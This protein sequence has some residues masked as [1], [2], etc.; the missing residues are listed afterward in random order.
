MCDL[1]D[2][3]I[4]LHEY[5]LL[6]RRCVFHLYR[7]YRSDVL[8]A[9]TVSKAG[10]FFLATWWHAVSRTWLSEPPEFE[11]EN[12]LGRHLTTKRPLKAR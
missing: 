4:I 9:T 2:I 8:N 7:K 5:L 6:S 3:F 12:R 1:F 10:L 11:L